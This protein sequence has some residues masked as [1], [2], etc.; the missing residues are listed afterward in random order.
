MHCAARR[1]VVRYVLVNEHTADARTFGRRRISSRMD[2]G[3]R[4]KRLQISTQSCFP[5]LG[6]VPMGRV[7][8]IVMNAPRYY[9]EH[10]DDSS[11]LD[12]VLR[13]K[14]LKK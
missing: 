11:A 13:R 9:C 8:E 2:G 7:S 3:G 5:L 1:E 14:L 10:G 4:P 12:P 6:L